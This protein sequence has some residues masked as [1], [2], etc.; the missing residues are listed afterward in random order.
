MQTIQLAGRGY[1]KH[2]HDSAVLL[3]GVLLPRNLG[4]L[5][6]ALENAPINGRAP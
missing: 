6:R 1:G 4:R 3:F 5:V 2:R